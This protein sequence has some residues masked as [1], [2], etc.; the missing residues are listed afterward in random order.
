MSVV[1]GKGVSHW[2]N[3]TKYWED[4]SEKTAQIREEAIKKASPYS[5]NFLGG[6]DWLR[7]YSGPIVEADVDMD[8]K[9][10]LSDE[11]Q[12]VRRLT[13]IGGSDVPSIFGA[14]RFVSDV[15]LYF[16]KTG[17]SP[18]FETVDSTKEVILAYG[19]ACEDI[20]AKAWQLKY[21]ELDI[22]ADEHVYNHPRL[23]YLSANLDR[24]IKLSDGGWAIGEIKCPVVYQTINSW[25]SGTEKVVP[26]EYE[27]QA[28]LY[29]AI[30][31]VWRAR[32]A[33]MYSPVK[34]LYREIYRDLDKEADIL[35]KCQDFWEN[36]VLTKIPPEVADGRNAELALK[37]F[38][39][40]SDQV[41]KSIR[42]PLSTEGNAKEIIE[43]KKKICAMRKE[44]K[45][46]EER[47]S[48][49]SVRIA[50]CMNGSE[51]AYIDASDGKT[52]E[53]SFELQTG[54]KK[55]DETKLSEYPE[56][57]ARCVSPGTIYRNL[58][59]SEF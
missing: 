14:S 10:V 23:T 6:E 33:V 31:G 2:L 20:C 49:L 3:G 29:M 43:L 7:N 52:Y 47:I 26:I 28:R 59:V 51:K 17:V 1:S 35:G 4:S 9:T 45:T 32:F 22:R 30:M 27:L 57:Y 13:H 40:Y 25:Y 53:I 48:F 18:K 56:A 21:P 36:H 44:I 24:M 8:G 15:E 5:I 58:S 39:Q 37:A 50:E 38:G 46:I 55:I 12:N 16:K 42:L 11:E 34:I 54:R 19:H 41:T